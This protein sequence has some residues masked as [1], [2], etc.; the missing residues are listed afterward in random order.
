[1]RKAIKSISNKKYER[2]IGVDVSTRSIAIAMV[3]GGIP[4]RLISLALPHGDF[5]RRLSVARR[6][7]DAVLRSFSPQVCV[8]ESPIMV[9]NPLSTKQLSYVVGV[10]F[11]QCLERNIVVEDVPPMTWKSFLGYRTIRRGERERIIENLGETEGRKEISRIRKGQI[12]DKLSERYPRFASIIRGDDDL[13]DALGVALYA[14]D[15]FGLVKN[16]DQ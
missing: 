1:M 12:Q 11:G 9:Q 16:Q 10:L 13:S 5:Y 3:E 14:W 6:R 4:T 2:V 8:I 15:R 7:F